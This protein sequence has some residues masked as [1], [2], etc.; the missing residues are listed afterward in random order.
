MKQDMKAYLQEAFEA[1]KPERKETFL[2]KVGPVQISTF[3]FV[4]SQIGYIRKRVWAVSVLILL[5][6]LVCADYVGRESLWI[7]SAL[8]PYIALCA[9]AESARSAAYGMTE[10][11]MST[12][13]SLRSVTLARLVS[14]GIL[15]LLI[16]CVLIPVAGELSLCPII[17][18]GIYV[19]LP[20]LLTSVLGLTLVRRVQDKEMIYVC[21]GSAVLVSILCVWIR[22]FMSWL[23]E[24][25]Y[26]I[27]WCVLVV[28]LL[29]R[30]IKE[31][32]KMIYQTE[33]LSWN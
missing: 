2:R 22:G 31:Y 20:Y 1:P 29:G 6:A 12:R 5:L 15:H 8:V 19:I 30:V 21:M 26:F 18:A 17:K 4:K 25:K 3:T 16:L 11:E 10:L 9:V 33:E 23:Y 32:K 14:I 27:W 7:I 24:E 13:F 28:Y